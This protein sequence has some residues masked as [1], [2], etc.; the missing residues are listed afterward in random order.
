MIT[1][2]LPT[3]IQKIKEKT[4]MSDADI[5]AKI[6]EKMDQ[7]SGLISRE[8]AAHIIANENGVVIMPQNQGRLEIKNVLAGMRSVEVVGKVVAIYEVREFERDGR[9]SQVGNFM[10][11]DK[12]G[13]IRVVAW[14]DKAK[15]LSEIS[16][17]DIIKIS[18]AFVRNNRDRPEIHLNDRTKLELN[19]EGEKV[20]V[21]ATRTS[22]A[23]RKTIKELTTDDNNA[24]VLATIVQ[25][26]DPRYFVRK[27]G[28]GE[29]FVLNTFLDDGTDSIRVAFFGEQALALLGM[30]MEEMLMFKDNLTGFE[31]K[32]T[33]LLGQVIL[34]SGRVNKNDMFDRVEMVANSV[35][36][37]PDP[38]AEMKKLS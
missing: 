25:V 16:V 33:E 22:D 9:K 30:K 10:I 15:I 13:S 37:K 1:I 17:G 14:G 23:V 21:V 8:G 18:D 2:P 7:L 34:V 11:A 31:E 20:D 29:S 5:E 6:K 38:E 3:L 35:N 12:S 27:D 24:E 4:D 32:K 26:F 19:P 28:S 36:P